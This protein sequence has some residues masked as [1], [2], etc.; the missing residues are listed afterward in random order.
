[1]VPYSI[2]LHFIS[3]YGSFMSAYSIWIG[4][5]TKVLVWNPPRLLRGLAF[6]KYLEFLRVRRCSKHFTS[7]ILTVTPL[8]PSYSQGNCGSES[9]SDCPKITSAGKRCSQNSNPGGQLW[10][11]QSCHLHHCSELLRCWLCRRGSCPLWKPPREDYVGVFAT[12][13]QLHFPNDSCRLSNKSDVCLRFLQDVF[14][15]T[16]WNHGGGSNGFYC[17]FFGIS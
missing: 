3:L 9:L 10:H 17:A 4:M 7:V 12:A 11:H 14:D 2:P 13:V 15:P 16:S 1:M 5:T 8:C 6:L